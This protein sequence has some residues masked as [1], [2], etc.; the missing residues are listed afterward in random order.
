MIDLDGEQ[1]DN[2]VV[3]VVDDV[4]NTGKTLFYSLKPQIK[5]DIL[6][7]IAVMK[8]ENAFDPD[9]ALD[10]EDI[11]GTKAFRFLDSEGKSD[12][13]SWVQ[14]MLDRVSGDPLRVGNGPFFS[15]DG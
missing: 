3:I 9:R 6:F 1:L 13:L 12:V 2:K 4:A 11:L 5:L 15:P 14:S 8:K 10:L 7:L